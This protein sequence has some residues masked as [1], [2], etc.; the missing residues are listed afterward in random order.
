ML[1]ILIFLLIVFALGLGFAWLADRPGELVATFGGYRYQ[2]SLIVAA[3]II[4]AVIAAVMIGWWL[5]KAIWN[6]PRSVSRYFRARSRDRGYQAL[7]TGMIA[8]GAG[9]AALARKMNKQ[10]AKLIR[11]DQEPLIHLLEAQATL[12]EGN[13]AAAREKFEAML[14]D[15]ETRLLGL[16]GLFLE[17]H[18]LGD[19]NAAR[20]Y[21]ARAGELAP[22]LGWAAESTLEQKTAEG[23]WDG[24]LRLVEAQKGHGLDKEATSR[25][26][27]VLL[28]AKAMALLDTDPLTARNAGLEAH[29]LRPA[30]A[31]AAL[32]AA[33]A[34]FRQNDIRKGA[35]VLEETWRLEPHPEIAELYLHARHGDATHDRLSRARKLQSMKQNHAESSMAVARAAL[36]AHEYATARDAADTA[37][38]M[39]PSENAFLLRADIEEAETGDQGRMRYWLGKALRAPRDAAWVADGYVAEHW[40]PVSPVTGRLDAFEWRVPMERLGQVID[41]DEPA[42]EP[43][44]LPAPAA[45]DAPAA[46]TAAAAPAAPA[47]AAAPAE[48]PAFGGVL[49]TTSENMAVARPPSL[50]ES[51]EPSLATS[52]SSEHAETTPPRDDFPDYEP[53]QPPI[54]ETDA[55][56]APEEFESVDVVPIRL[57][58]DPGVEEEEVRERRRGFRLF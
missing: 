29:R 44:A 52:Q 47:A 46:L 49:S 54:N 12:L 53:D 30:F 9:D 38:R 40:A 23:D 36:G 14:D 32:I 18:R 57:P 39:R 17:A 8:A 31:P 41:A 28:T 20:H 35:K 7:S 1:R 21:A 58:D 15:P 26:R 45:A 10:A 16:R 11:A 24:A 56:T 6:S 13:H 5:V 48:E 51:V 25:R 50:T 42:P 27:S 4:T 3:A 34:L 43:P 55:A 37:I 19:M 22:Q 33:R 2:I